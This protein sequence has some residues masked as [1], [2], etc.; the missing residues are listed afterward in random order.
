MIIAYYSYDHVKNPCCGGGGAYRD[1]MIH[2]QLAKKHALTCYCGKIKGVSDY[3][4]D[5]ITFSFLGSATNYLISRI[6]FSLAATLH[7]LFVKADV[8]VIC[9]SVYSPVVSFLFRKRNTIIEL[10]HLTD[11]GPFRKYSLFGL[12][13][14]IAEKLAL[15]AGRHFIC[16]NELLTGFIKTR[17][18]KKS[19]TTVYTGFDTRLISENRGDNHY[20]LFLGRIDIYMKGIDL[21]ID[22]FE[23][24]SRSFPDHRLIIGQRFTA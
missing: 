5:Q 22:A 18:K 11:T 6:T 3:S 15:V 7:A 4:E 1:L 13:P 9:Y 23:T 20:V 2:R 24:I 19:V 16:I 8:I 21:L 12:A 10:F 17:Y 14:F